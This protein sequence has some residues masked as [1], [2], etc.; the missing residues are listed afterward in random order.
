MNQTPS[1]RSAPDPAVVADLLRRLNTAA[2][3]VNDPKATR[4]LV[5][6]NVSDTELDTAI[7]RFE[8]AF[9]VRAAV[10]AQPVVVFDHQGGVVPSRLTRSTLTESTDLPPDRRLWSL[11]LEFI[12]E[13]V[14]ARGW[15][16]YAARFGASPESNRDSAVWEMTARYT[17]SVLETD[18][19][20]GD[21]PLIG[22]FNATLSPT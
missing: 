4:A 8:A 18:C 3:A 21:L 1:P 2:L 14:P 19:H 12:A 5:V 10:G 16:V 13:S 20:P 22:R 9:P 17:G 6:V 11:S 15:R 7:V